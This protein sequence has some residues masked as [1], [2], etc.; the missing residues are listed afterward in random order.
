M[1]MA[2]YW[3]GVSGE[4]QYIDVSIQESVERHALMEYTDWK[5]TGIK[6][7]LQ[8]DNFVVPPQRAVRKKIGVYKTTI[9][10]HFRYQEVFMRGGLYRLC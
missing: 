2:L 3:R 4:G 5:A 7:T 8:G 10:R 6:V 1:A 9:T